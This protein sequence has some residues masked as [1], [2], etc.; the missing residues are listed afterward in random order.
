MAEKEL[1]TF[2]LPAA[3]EKRVLSREMIVNLPP[4]VKHWLVRSNVINR[5]II[6]TSFVQQK[7][8]MRTAPDGRWMPFTAEQWVRTEKPGFFW[9]ADVEAAPGVHLAGR[10]KYE[11]GKGH[12]LIKLLSLI[13][14]ADA[15]GNTIDQGSLVRYLAEIIWC[16]SA[17]VSEL[18]QWE[19]IDA[20]RAKAVMTYGGITATGI[21]TFDAQGDVVSFEARRYY[22]RKGGATLEDWFIS[23]DTSSYR[24]FEGVRVA[25]RSTV[26]WKVKDGDFTWFRLEVTDMK[27][28][29][30]MNK[31]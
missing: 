2:L 22:D 20:T 19:P 7:G 26:T 29:T 8:E 25:A 28:N 14:I 16:P 11:D 13:P 6:R 31:I 21:F 24:E 12:M 30:M 1:K 27:Y 18:V 9:L 10:D 3:D 17:A 5:E 4:V 15:R 23:I